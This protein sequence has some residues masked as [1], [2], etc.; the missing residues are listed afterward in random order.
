MHQHLE[1]VGASV[2]EQ[3]G[4][5]WP[6]L[7]EDL[8]DAGQCGLGAARMSS[9]STASQMASTRINAGLAGPGGQLAAALVG[10][11]A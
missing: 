3:V 4:V 2:G 10:R 6:R 1:A 8:N 7:A 5:V 9:G 11:D